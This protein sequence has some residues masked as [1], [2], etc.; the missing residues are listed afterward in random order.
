MNIIKAGRRRLSTQFPSADP[1]PHI[2]CPFVAFTFDTLN[3]GK[4]FCF[5]I[6]AEKKV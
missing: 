2:L 4:V 6:E 3:I 1:Q 5:T